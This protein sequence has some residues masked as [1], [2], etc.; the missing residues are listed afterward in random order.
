MIRVLIADDHQLFRAGL[1]RMLA[2][3]P[4]VK[5]VGE[6]ASGEEA[7]SLARELRPNVV[8][9]NLFMPGIGGTEACR[10]I[11]ALQLDIKVLILSGCTDSP[12]PAQALR[13]G[14]T[15]YV[16]KSIQPAELLVAVK[17]AFVGKRYLSQEVAHQLALSAFDDGAESP[18]E[19]LS[20]R[21]MQIMLM[22]VNCQKVTEISTNQS[23]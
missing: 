2:D 9:M 7:V 23:T 21:E 15:G 5:L 19:Q 12:F 22:V 18:F 14:A 11:V 1:I 4:T 6:A 10:R 16:S 13:A 8:L 17:K 20:G 3:T